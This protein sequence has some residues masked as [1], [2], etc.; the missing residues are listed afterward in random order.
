MAAPT[1]HA[2]PDLTEHHPEP[3]SGDESSAPPPQSRGEHAHSYPDI[4]DAVWAMQGL[5]VRVFSF[6][7]FAPRL[8]SV[9]WI[10][11]GPDCEDRLDVKNTRKGAALPSQ[12]RRVPTREGDDH[13]GNPK[14]QRHPPSHLKPR[15]CKRHASAC[16]PQR[17]GC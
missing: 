11:P 9:S 4:P 17:T 16:T 1:R 3:N 15:L 10:A 13:P 6:P 8:P 7:I 12:L 5:E 14:P 2:A